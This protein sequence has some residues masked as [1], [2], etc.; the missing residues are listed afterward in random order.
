QRRGAVK[1]NK[2]G[3]AGLVCLVQV[4]SGAEAAADRVH[5]LFFAEVGGIGLGELVPDQRLEDLSALRVR[6]QVLGEAELATDERLEERLDLANFLGDPHGR[7]LAFAATERE[8]RSAALDGDDDVAGQLDV[9]VVFHS[10][11]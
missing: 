3:V 2:P 8:P 11:G 5:D 4:I 10:K 7:G 6:G 9:Y 1:A